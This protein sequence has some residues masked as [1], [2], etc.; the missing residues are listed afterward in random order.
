MG[1][2]EAGGRANSPNRYRVAGDQFIELLERSN[3]VAYAFAEVCA[4]GNVNS[5]PLP[6]FSLVA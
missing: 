3:V 2:A 5:L 1:R 4:K 6:C